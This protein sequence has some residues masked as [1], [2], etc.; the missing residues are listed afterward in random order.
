MQTQALVVS[1]GTMEWANNWIS[2]TGVSFPFLLD[3]DRAVYR[4]YELERSFLRIWNPNVLVSYARLL[5]KGYSLK[6]VMGDPYQLGADFV[7]DK[8]GV[9]RLSFYSKNPADRPSV[10]TLISVVRETQNKAQQLLE[11]NKIKKERR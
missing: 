3:A 5:L 9:V 7:V 2:E 1:Y 8:E 6:P 10:E 4:L 11:K